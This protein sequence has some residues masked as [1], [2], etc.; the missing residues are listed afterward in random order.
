[1]LSDI[2]DQFTRFLCESS[3]LQEHQLLALASSSSMRVST[4]FSPPRVSA[5]ASSCKSISVNGCQA[6]MN[7]ATST[8]H[9]CMPVVHDMLITLPFSPTITMTPCPPS[10]TRPSPADAIDGE[11]I[12]ATCTYREASPLKPCFSKM[13]VIIEP[14]LLATFSDRTSY[15]TRDTFSCGG[16]TQGHCSRHLQAMAEVRPARPSFL[17]SGSD[18]ALSGQDILWT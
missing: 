15:P 4:S 17:T 6:P 14:A 5:F 8:V 12:Q 9:L 3:F 10:M 18:E 16:M 11:F 1:M 7:C 2:N 13:C